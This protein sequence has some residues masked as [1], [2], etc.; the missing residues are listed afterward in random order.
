[1]AGGMS[2]PIVNVEAPMVVTTNRLTV[3]VMKS[4]LKQSTTGLQAAV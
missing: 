4:G 1:M 3:A 2:F